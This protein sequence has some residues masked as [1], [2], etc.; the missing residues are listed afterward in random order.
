MERGK[1]A[2]K[3]IEEEASSIVFWGKMTASA[4][5]YKSADFASSSLA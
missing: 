2:V 1:V 4:L 3:N 5:R